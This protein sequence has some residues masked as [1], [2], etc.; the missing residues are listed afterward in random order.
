MNLLG[1]RIPKA[2]EALAA[3]KE[4]MLKKKKNEKGSQ[5]KNHGTLIA[6]NDRE[7]GAVNALT[8]V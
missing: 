1:L 2:L 8:P 3:P 7:R 6:K 4:G 5:E